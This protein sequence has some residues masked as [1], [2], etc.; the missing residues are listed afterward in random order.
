MTGPRMAGTR[1]LVVEDEF[2]LAIALEDLLTDE[3]CI[4][5]GPFAREN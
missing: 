1:V 3:G 4:V 5:I 2:L